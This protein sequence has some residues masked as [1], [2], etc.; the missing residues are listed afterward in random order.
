MP[1]VISMIDPCLHGSCDNTQSVEM[2]IMPSFRSHYPIG[3]DI[4]DQHIYALQLKQAKKGLTIR[5]LWH[6]EFDGHAESLPD[7][8]E[9]F[10]ALLK[11]IRKSKR[12]QGKS[13]AVHL[14]S[15]NIISFPIRF[16]IDRTESFEENIL[17]ESEKQL[18][19]PID[20]A[21]IDYPSI[22][23]VAT[24]D[25][26]DYK[27]TIVAARRDSL[28]K[29][30]S[31]LAR[32]G[33]TV[34]TIDFGVASLIRLHNHYHEKTQN[35]AILCNIGFEESLLTVVSKNSILAQRYFTWGF[36]IL[37]DKILANLELTADKAEFL[38]NSYGLAYDN[39]K[40]GADPNDPSLDQTLI[41]LHRALYKIITPYIDE[42]IYEF[43]AIM[44]Y[45]RSEEQISSFDGIHMYGYANV[46]H[47]LD[48][49]LAK[50]LESIPVNLINPLTETTMSDDRS[51]SNLSEDAPFALALGLA[52]RKV[53]WL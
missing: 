17:R 5:G 21:I 32:A 39:L 44:S 30:L 18:S 41:N 29:Y 40:N 48:S 10:V 1:C 20:E 35:T 51:L 8:D 27:A 46:L 15:Q 24:G 25:R 23:S 13:V 50:R 22:D 11:E 19:F 47:H 53:T 34:E 42:L 3:I 37:L 12:F 49:Y 38:L 52:M 43:H 45:V 6:R 14:P 2:L 33:L 28:L 4:E 16:Q 36:R 31:A 26:I 9:A 7:E